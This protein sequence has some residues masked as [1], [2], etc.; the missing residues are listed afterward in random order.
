MDELMSAT[1]GDMNQQQRVSELT[2]R[3]IKEN[4]PS[5][6]AEVKDSAI[7]KKAMQGDGD[8]ATIKEILGWVVDTV[9]ETLQL[10][11]KRMAELLSLMETPPS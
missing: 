8:W 1:Q 10:P 2:L 11:P 5:L 3:V 9:S 7:L 6:P 4:F